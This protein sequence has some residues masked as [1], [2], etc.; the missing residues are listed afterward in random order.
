MKICINEKDNRVVI[1][2]ENDKEKFYIKEKIEQ[3]HFVYNPTYITWVNGHRI[4]SK[5]TT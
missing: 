2:W 4:E 3:L 5:A 1:T